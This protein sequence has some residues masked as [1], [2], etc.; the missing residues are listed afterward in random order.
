MGNFLKTFK[1][2]KTFCIGLNKTGTTTIGQFFLDYKYKIG[3]QVE[4]EYLVDDWFHRDF[5]KIIRYC[6]KYEAF[7]DAPFS[8]PF[9]YVLLDQHF[10]NAKFILTSRDTPEQWYNSLTKFHSKLW[11]NGIDPPTAQ[12]LKDASYRYKGYAYEVNRALFNTPENDVYKK[13]VLIAYYN[14]HLEAVKEYFR[15]RPEKLISINVSNKNDYFRLCEFLGKKP[16]SDNFS[17][18]NKTEE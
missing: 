10:P 9:T 5:K 17:W 8:L 7:Q 4:A 16:V 13:D 1:S 14:N 12:Q 18:K 11:S 6:K 3:N 2:S 15:S